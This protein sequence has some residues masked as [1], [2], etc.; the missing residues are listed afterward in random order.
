VGATIGARLLG[1]AK[2]R[3]LRLVFG[4]VILALAIEMIINGFTGRI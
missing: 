3:V 4:L 1:G 2:V